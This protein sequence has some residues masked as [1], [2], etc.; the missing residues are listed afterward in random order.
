M[1]AEVLRNL[2]VVSGGEEVDIQWTSLLENLLEHLGFQ[3][4]V[5][6][7]HLS[8]WLLVGSY[9]QFPRKM[10]ILNGEVPVTAPVP[11]E[12]SLVVEFHWSCLLWSSGMQL[13]PCCPFA[14]G[15][16]DSGGRLQMTPELIPLPWAPGDWCALSSPVL[17]ISHSQISN[18]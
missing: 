6:G 15:C 13:Q 10:Y 12:Q 18:L 14:G 16:A 2:S 5:A 11:N 9:I 1:P 3:F 4:P 7:L 17:T 8:P